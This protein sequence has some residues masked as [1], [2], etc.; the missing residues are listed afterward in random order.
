MTLRDALLKEFDLESPFTRRSLERV[1]V[2]KF[3]WK[4]HEKSMT[5]GRL[6]TFLAMVPSWGKIVIE[7]PGLDAGLA[8]GA[9]PEFPTSSQELLAM[10]D[11][12]CGRL[13]AALARVS[14]YHLETPWTLKFKGKVFF[15]QP[16]WL[17]LRAFIL[18]H[19]THHRAQLGVY[20][21]LLGIPVPAIYNASA[22]EPG[23]LFQES[24]PASGTAATGR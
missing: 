13:R 3:G 20:L 12:N 10:F 17:A 7:Q 21:R 14:N 18:N 16:R 6:A 24:P 19:I 4:P 23:G 9:R 5:L 2:E 22:D 1:P 15:T 8:A 11:E